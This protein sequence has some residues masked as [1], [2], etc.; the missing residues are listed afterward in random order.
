MT[1][2]SRSIASP[3]TPEARAAR[4]GGRDSP[5]D[6]CGGR[7]GLLRPDGDARR[8]AYDASG[9]GEADEDTVDRGIEGHVS[10][11]GDEDGEGRGGAGGDG[12]EHRRGHPG[13]ADTGGR[14]G[15]ADQDADGQG[16]GAGG[17]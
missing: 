4:H 7:R 11:T 14:V 17:R 8:A 10:E 15:L 9:V 3:G 13:D 6:G 1:P 5:A 16:G 2:Y 12:G